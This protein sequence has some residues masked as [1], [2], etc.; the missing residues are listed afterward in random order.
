MCI[1]CCFE[2]YGKNNN[3]SFGL[4]EGEI[5]KEGAIATTWAHDHHNLM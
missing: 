1:N 2:R 5:I 4:V 3:I